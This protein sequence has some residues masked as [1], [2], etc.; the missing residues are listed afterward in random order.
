MFGLKTGRVGALGRIA[1]SGGRPTLD[2][3][4]TGG[5]A[6][7]RLTTTRAAGGATYY[8]QTGTLQLANANTPRIDYGPGVVTNLATQSN[9]FTTGN[10]QKQAGVSVTANA[11]AAPDG[12]ITATRV[13]WTT[14]VGQ[15]IFQ[16]PSVPVSSTAPNTKSIYV[17]ADVAGGTVALTDAAFTIGTAIF[18]LTTSWQRISLTEIATT[19]IADIWLKKRADSPNIIYIAWAQL[20]NNASSPGI[21]VPTAGVIASANTAVTNWTLQSGTPNG[22]AP[23]GNRNSPTMTSGQLAPDGT[24]TAY[25]FAYGSTTNTIY[26]VYQDIIN[27]GVERTGAYY[28]SSVYAKA[29]GNNWLHLQIWNFFS[30]GSGLEAWFNLQTGVLGS[31]GTNGGASSV[32]STITSVGNGWYRCS[33]SGIL[34]TLAGR[35]TVEQNFRLSQANG[36]SGTTG[37]IG[38]GTLIWHPQ[39]EVAS[40]ASAYLPTTATTSTVGATALGLLIEESRVNSIR[41]PRFEGAVVGTPGTYPTDMTESHNTGLTPNV[42]GFGYE[43][44]IPYWDIQLSGTATAGQNNIFFEN[45]NI[46][47]GNNQVWTESAYMR[48]VAGSLTNVS[49]IVLGINDDVAGGNGIA[50]VPSGSALG[51]QRFTYT[52]TLSATA[53]VIV[54]AFM[55][56]NLAAG[57]VNITLRIGAPQIEL[58]AF[59]T[60]PILPAIGTPAATTRAADIVSMPV[61]GWFNSS[62]GTLLSD[63]TT[64]VNVSL[65]QEFSGLGSDANNVIRTVSAAGGTAPFVQ[66]FVAGV[67]SGG[68][69]PGGS[70]T[71]GV[72][73]RIAF[74]YTR[75]SLVETASAFGL[76]P[77]SATVSAMPTMTTLYL[78]SGRGSV[79]NGYLRR[80]RYWPRALSNAELIRYTT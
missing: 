78:G 47:A 13:D 77:I 60:S 43:N 41:N 44:G 9:D 17:R 79:N 65:N 30:P 42:I 35:L 8:D 37:V 3:P 6:D 72:P 16:I 40:T 51:S 11:V 22:S 24:S 32:S 62:I 19:G 38:N 2:L 71:A 66:T 68:P 28:T 36:D 21:Y 1:G 33:L 70:A 45:A 23:W 75:S 12:T 29:A 31:T 7:S 56:F 73:F 20:E 55:Q 4:F 76:S 27:V 48:V 58:G 63:Q 54:N 34:Q 74:T 25:L 52:R 18:T 14:A 57:A 67:N 10:W 49:A 61:G 53:T 59:A 5:S 39:L 50:L 26:D 69:S 64:V 80:V 46:S 15:G